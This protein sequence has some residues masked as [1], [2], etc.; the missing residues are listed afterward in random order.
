[1]PG[2]PGCNSQTVPPPDL[3]FSVNIPAGGVILSPPGQISQRQ[4]LCE[5][6]DA[7]NLRIRRG[8]NRAGPFQGGPS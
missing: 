1:M 3:H 4:V 6:H 5:S 2:S 7:T 8:S